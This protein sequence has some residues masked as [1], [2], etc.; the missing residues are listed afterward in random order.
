MH[1]SY[2][3][4][5]AQDVYVT[6][7]H[8]KQVEEL[9]Y[10]VKDQLL[11][12]LG[13][14]CIPQTERVNIIQEAHASLIIG[15]F[16]VSK[17]VAHLQRFCY[18]PRMHE[19]VSRYIKG[20]TTC[21]K[22]KPNNI[23]IGLYTPLLVP[24]HH[25]ESVSMDFVGGLPKS[26]N[27]HDYLYVVVDRFNKMCILIPR[28]KQVTTEQIVIPTSFWVHFGL[29]TSIVSDQDSRFVGKFWSSL[30]ELMDN[31]LKKSTKF[32]VQTYGQT[33]VVNKT[34]IQLL[35]GYCSRH[36]KLLDEH[37]CYVQHAYNRAKHSSTQRSPLET[38]FGFTQKYPL[39]FVFG[40]D[41]VVDGHNDVD[42]ATKFI[43]QI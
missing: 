2:I 14:L 31:R 5:Y 27:G 22:S 13:N 7:S 43:E 4:Q 24:S 1:E 41:I 3:E 34:V 10:Y 36:P 23:K 17:T 6:L 38:C 19:T 9:D 8:G 25:G 35:K 11:Y 16:G 40:K 26:R 30:W 37:L 33:E 21:P 20:C 32:H 39:D 18:W 12:H 28:R 42:K 29:P 15:H